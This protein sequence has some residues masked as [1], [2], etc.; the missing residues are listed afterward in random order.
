[1]LVTDA[2]S[3]KIC[4]ICADLVPPKA[5]EQARIPTLSGDLLQMLEQGNCADVRFDVCG[6]VVWAHKFLLVTR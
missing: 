3:K 2:T 1:M 4:I 6:E 5:P